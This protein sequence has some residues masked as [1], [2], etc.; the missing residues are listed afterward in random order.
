M[1]SE[2]KALAKRRLIIETAVMLF[3]EKGF[4]QTSIRDIANK[5]GISLG[6]LY[7]HFA[8]KSELIAAIAL[9][10]A[11]EQ[12]ILEATL[13]ASSKPQKALDKFINQYIAIHAQPE[14]AAISAEILSEAIRNPS[15][16][17]GFA[18]NQNR[19]IVKLARLLTTGQ[20]L[21]CLDF[22]NDVLLTAQSII[23]ILE[24]ASMKSIFYSKDEKKRYLKHIKE[25]VFN[26]VGVKGS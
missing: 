25:L 20:N 21:G 23:D 24:S 18:E 5:A 1:H 13:T 14:D 9:L 8:G 12:I 4:H 10:E 17:K 22:N 3:I 11:E 7:N 16:A 26:I 19:L 2:E 6:N 15:I